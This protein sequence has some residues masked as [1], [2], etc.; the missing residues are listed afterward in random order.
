[1]PELPDLE[2]FSTNLQKK[3][4]GKKLQ[5]VRVVNKKKLKVTPAKLKKSLEGSALKKV[6]REGKEIHFAFSNGNVLGWHLMLRGG[7][8]AF[9]K[10]NDAKY[11]IMELLFSNSSG[12]AL[13]DYQSAATPT[14]NPEEKDAPDALS[15]EID[16]SFL[17]ELLSRKKTIIKNVLLDQKSIRGIGN[18]YAD[19]ILWKAGISPFSVANKIPDEKIRVLTK[20]IPS[21]LQN[22][23]KQ[24]RKKNP[25]IISG[26]VRDF[27]KIHNSKMK[28]S[29]TG[30]KIVNKMINGR[31]TYYSSEQKLFK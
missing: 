13:T 8:S 21:V 10:K 1:M 6:Y 24:I 16:F 5:Q 30:G 29:P 15:K 14:L 12:L 23:I 28:K 2:V 3:F 9:E 31:I 25:D 20:A 27:L 11:T 19:E 22:A 18:A 17:K 7:M 4:A 26:E